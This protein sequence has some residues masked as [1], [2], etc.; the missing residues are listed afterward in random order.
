MKLLSF[1][2]LKNETEFNEINLE[3]ISK[4]NIVLEPTP[5][6]SIETKEKIGY[7]K[8]N[9]FSTEKQELQS[10]NINF[11]LEKEN[12]IL[13]TLSSNI[14]TQ[15]NDATYKI[16][17]ASNFN[18]IFLDIQGFI[19]I[20]DKISFNE[21]Y[22]KIIDPNREINAIGK[23]PEIIT[24]T[25]STFTITY[26]ENSPLLP[27]GLS[28]EN[29]FTIKESKQTIINYYKYI[30]NVDLPSDSI[31]I[32]GIG[33]T[34]LIGA[35]YY[36]IQKILD[37]DITIS[38][39]TNDPFYT[40][41]K[42]I[43][44]IIPKTKWEKNN[45]TAD[46]I[47]NVSPN[48]PNGRITDLQ[49][50]LLNQYI[51]YDVVY[52]TPQF[53]GKFESV[54][55]KFFEDFK[56]NNNLSFVNSFSKMGLP[57]IRTGYLITRNTN[58]LKYVNEYLIKNSLVPN[59]IGI[60]L[61]REAYYRF[62]SKKEWYIE[63]NEKIKKRYIQF[64]IIALKYDLTILNY[65]EFVPY[66]YVNRSDI[67]WLNKFNITTLS[68]IDFEDTPQNSRFNLLINDND[69]EEFILRTL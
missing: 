57:G 59:N 17:S 47:I 4:A 1:Y 20:I 68:G 67:W 36:A 39:N 37:K 48:N 26:T 31:I 28:F 53:T 51:L 16:L 35:Y 54:N 11:F 42:S 23:E 65:T 18:N 56:K 12:L 55:K 34:E 9:M 32:Y 27:G 24:Q 22:I 64:K 58:I 3:G 2:Y 21:V 6:Y 46:L 40:L 61:S 14:I 41:C 43:T 15:N 63:I 10:K 62:F 33:A 66:I 19:T 13:N 69:W 29:N 25:M 60:T 5:L 7:I 38:T 45:N 8:I 52:D 50:V 30:L 44:T 49:N